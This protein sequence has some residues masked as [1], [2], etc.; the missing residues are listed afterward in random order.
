MR[1]RR[2]RWEED[3]RRRFRQLVAQ[4]VRAECLL[5]LRREG[6]APD[7]R[8][9]WMDL[10]QDT[11]SGWHHADLFRQHL[12]LDLIDLVRAGPPGADERS[13][14]EL[15]HVRSDTGGKLVDLIVEWRDTALGGEA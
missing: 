4:V 2:Q 3:V 8:L 6:E 13:D 10:G 11:R 1:A 7:P 5:R 9:V 12:G 14:G 15:A